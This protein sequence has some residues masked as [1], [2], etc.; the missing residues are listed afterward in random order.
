MV[1]Y[2]WIPLNALFSSI[3][4]PLC[5]IRGYVFIRSFSS[6]SGKKAVLKE[7][8]PPRVLAIVTFQGNLETPDE[9]KTPKPQNPTHGGNYLIWSC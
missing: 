8:L 6:G 9:P 3:L 5:E 4:A 1:W 2:E 7:E